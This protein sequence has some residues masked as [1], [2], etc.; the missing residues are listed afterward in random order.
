MKALT[1][2]ILL[3]L[4]FSI[5][6]HAQLEMKQ[7]VLGAGITIGMTPDDID[8]HA[9]ERG[10]TTIASSTSARKFRSE[11]NGMTGVYEVRF[12]KGVVSGVTI[13]YTMT[14]ETAKRFGG[15]VKTMKQVMINRAERTEGRGK[16][17]VYINTASDGS[18]I[19]TRWIEKGTRVYGLEATVSGQK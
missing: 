8:A 6:A 13:N 18:T 2:S 12:R 14:K 9:E 10:W 11:S 4:L 5:T 15:M 7:D 16:N 1:L 3:L 19:R 17:K